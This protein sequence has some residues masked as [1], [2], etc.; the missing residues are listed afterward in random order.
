VEVAYRYFMRCRA[1]ASI[2]YNFHMSAEPS[3]DRQEIVDGEHLRI[4]AICYYVLGGMAIVI[5]SFALLYVAFGLL[6]A[7]TPQFAHDVKRP[8][9]AAAMGVIGLLMMGAGGLFVCLGWLHGGLQIFVGRA[10]QQRRHRTL[11]LAVAMFTCLSIPLG[12][13]VGVFTLIV[14]MR[15]S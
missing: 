6:L 2:A 13:L 3:P 15:P 1:G 5:S 10:L 8:N 14:L 4:L 11:T 12:T 9:D 7:V